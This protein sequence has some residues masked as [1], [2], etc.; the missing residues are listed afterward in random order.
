[1]KHADKNNK[2]QEHRKFGELSFFLLRHCRCF[3]VSF[4]LRE[5]WFILNF[6]L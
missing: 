4:P 1:M 6:V 2:E 3:H 5:Q